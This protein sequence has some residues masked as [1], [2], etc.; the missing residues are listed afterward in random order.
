MRSEATFL[1]LGLMSLIALPSPADQMSHQQQCATSPTQD[2]LPAFISGARG[3]G[4]WLV[5][6]ADGRWDWAK[7]KPT[8]TLWILRTTHER[9]RIVG[10]DVNRG[11]RARFQHGGLGSPVTEAMTV[12]D[13]WRDSVAP[14]GAWE[15]QNRY[16]FLTSYVFYPAPG[17]YAFDVAIGD[18]AGTITIE[19]K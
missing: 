10:R 16:L 19:I 15:L 3:T 2:I 5:D 11:V 4:P 9:V 7:D 12:D 13:P 14:G 6:G 17:C 1:F 18:S 8:K